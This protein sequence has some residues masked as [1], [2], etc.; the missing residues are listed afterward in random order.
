MFLDKYLDSFYYDLVCDNYD[1]FYL[2]RLDETNFRDVYNIFS[3]YNFY[4][5]NDI[6][7]NYIELFEMNPIDVENGILKLKE[8]LG[9]DFV[10]IIGSDMKYLNEILDEELEDE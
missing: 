7:L 1:S 6:I 3:K 9:N 8:K 5:I 2:E 4:F 10:Y